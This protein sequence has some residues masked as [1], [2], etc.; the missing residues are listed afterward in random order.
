MNER[1]TSIVIVNWNTPRHLEKAVQAVRRHTDRDYELI[2]VDNGSRPESRSLIERL[3]AEGPSTRSL[4]L[5]ENLGY[6]AGNNRGIALARGD[7]I[8][9]L[10]SDAFVT[11]GWLSSLRRSLDEHA[12]DMAGPCTNRCKGVQRRK[13][14]LS[15]FPPPAAFRRAQETDFLSFFCVLIRRRVF[16][17]IGVL[18]ERFEVGSWEDV[19]F[20]RRARES[21]HRL[22]VDGRSWV[23]HL[24]HAT[25][26]AN[27][28]KEED[29]RA[30]N[31]VVYDAKWTPSHEEPRRR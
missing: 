9:L 28:L 11:G 17:T 23:W 10:N 24:A 21:R 4:F 25:F 31:R 8:C 12:A 18:D 1:L 19:D 15:T 26:L 14:W 22:W 27:D 20:C 30:R 2:L 16:E 6:A 7:A 13:L 29:L 3:Q 5:P